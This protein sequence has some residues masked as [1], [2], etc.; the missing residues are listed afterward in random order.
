M[1][2]EAPLVLAYRRPVFLWLKLDLLPLLYM[3]Q[4]GLS[5]VHS[6]ELK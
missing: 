5:L 1:M 2:T 3:L 6:Y 4:L